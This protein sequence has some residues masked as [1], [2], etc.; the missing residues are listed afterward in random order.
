MALCACDLDDRFDGWFCGLDYVMMRR[1]EPHQ[2]HVYN[3]GE[4]FFRKWE[5]R[6]RQA[7]RKKEERVLYEY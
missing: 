1:K 7:K 5:P 2:R 4:E 6:F 3:C